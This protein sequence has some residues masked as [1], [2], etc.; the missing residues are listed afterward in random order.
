MPRR[1]LQAVDILIDRHDLVWLIFV[2]PRHHARLACGYEKGRGAVLEHD[3]GF[4]ALL[5]HLLGDFKLRTFRPLGLNERGWNDPLYPVG[6]PYPISYNTYAASDRGNNPSSLDRALTL[7]LGF[8]GQRDR[9]SAPRRHRAGG[10]RSLDRRRRGSRRGRLN[11]RRRSRPRRGLCSTT[12]HP[13]IGRQI[14]F[15]DDFVTIDKPFFYALIDRV[16]IVAG[17]IIIVLV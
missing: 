13:R 1:G 11:H 2:L 9:R 12:R 17:Q 6:L 14:F 16:V 5:Y 4:F 10:R 3:G 8:R 15:A 7:H